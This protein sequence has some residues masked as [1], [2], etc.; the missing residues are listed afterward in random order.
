MNLTN[1]RRSLL[2]VLLTLLSIGVHELG[3]YVVYTA[4]GQPVRVTLQ[5]VRPV[6]AVNPSL[7]IW[8][9]AAGPAI[10]LLVGLACLLL[11]R[12]RSSFAL[13]T[14]A[15]TNSS[16]RLFPLVMDA[17]R[18]VKGARPFSDEGEVAQ[19]LLSGVGG[20]LG[21]L[22]VLLG[23]SLLLSVLAVREYR[24]RRH[25]MLKG[26]GMYLLTLAVGIA[27]VILDEILR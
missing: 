16:I 25:P 9:K 5:S 11:C 7:D 8:A 14:A 22:A 3:H 18:A 12:G 26:L 23:T 20:R 24:F 2:L 6:G 4:G 10:S 27:V 21:L 13:T 19:A 1:L 15:L 17:S